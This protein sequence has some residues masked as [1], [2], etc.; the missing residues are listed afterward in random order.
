MKLHI[1][2]INLINELKTES[3]RVYFLNKIGKMD[4]DQELIE[5][6]EKAIF[7]EDIELNL[8]KN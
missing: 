7:V 8:E 2:I 1:Y 4:D 5:L 3:K 6:I